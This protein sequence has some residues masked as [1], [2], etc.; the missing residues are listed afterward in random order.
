MYGQHASVIGSSAGVLGESSSGDAGATGVFGHVLSTAPGG[1]SAGV[2]GINEGKGG[3]GV[4]V[5]GSHAGYGMGVYG[6]SPYGRGIWGFHTGAWS[7]LPAVE[8]D[9]NSRVPSATAVKGVMT[10]TTPAIGSVAVRGVNNGAAAYGVGVAGSQAGYGT[11]VYGTT[12]YGRG[13]FGEHTGAWGNAA[14][15]EGTT[16]SRVA[17]AVGVQGVVT[18]ANPADG[19]TGVR[20][21]NN[22][23]GAKG[24]GVW[25]SQAGSG[26][27]VYGFSP[28]GKGIVGETRS[29]YAGYSIGNVRVTETLS[30]AVKSF[31]IDHPLD[32][33]HKYLQHA[34]VESSEL[35][36]MYDG[37]ATTDA[38]G[39]ATVKLPAWFQALNGDFRY[40][41]TSLSGLQELAVAKEISHNRFTLQ[42]QK[43]FARVSWQV[44]GVRHDAY[45]R[46]HPLKVVQEKPAGVQG[47]YL[48]PAAYGQPQSKAEATSPRLP[49]W[50]RTIPR[51]K[52]API[53]R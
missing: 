44:T 20:G 18:N 14:A 37:I 29:G 6:I 28:L 43:P 31:Q 50:S 19:S 26:W 53:K 15:V 23:T 51:P 11:G 30:A 52:G 12:P 8:G 42:S 34:S 45:A 9:T 10:S 36:N 3:N 4:G 40:Q 13:V 39:F 22:G 21:I 32:P 47:T 46:A 35:K 33:A 7:E 17:S 2:R 49:K 41:L 16:N 48:D 1:S 24:I 38:K 5:W 25:G 27:G